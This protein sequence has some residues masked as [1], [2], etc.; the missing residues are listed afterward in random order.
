MITH[1]QTAVSGAD[2]RAQTKTVLLRTRAA[3]AGAPEPI[4]QADDLPA[5]GQAFLDHLVR[6]NLLSPSVAGDF[7]RGHA[8][9]LAAFD[10]AKHT[11]D[12]LVQASL[13][14]RYQ[15]DRILAGNTHGLV[16]GNYRVLAQI[17]AGGM[18]VVFQGEHA[19]MR[20][21]VAIKVLPVDDGCPA[22]MLQR[23]YNEMRVLAQLN[24]P[25]IVTAYDSG[26]IAASAGLPLLL[27]LVMELVD[28]CDLEQYVQRNGRVDIGTA[29]RWICQAGSGLRE[30][31][32]HGLVHRDVKPSN[33]LLAKNGQ[34]K[35]VDFGLVRQFS[36]GLTDPKA[37][38]GTVEYM[39]PEQATDPSSVGTHA[40]IYA[41]GATLFLLLTGQPPYPP[42]ATMRAAVRQLQE[43]QPRRLLQ[44]RP[45][46]PPQLDAALSRLLDRDPMRRPPM[47]HNAMKLLEPFATPG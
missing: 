29:C 17:G 1:Q 4:I 47:V 33:L 45:D 10:D 37:T 12:A 42:T 32:A 39:S 34:I 20:R 11:G 28:G 36:N 7:L 43:G 38:L 9:R 24:H 6:L 27:Y 44:M 23:F 21:K 35:L 22:E 30:A 13:L 31:H 16:L 40:D 2:E 41:L 18:G 14:S 25:N 19:L 26:R 46:A 5:G 8:G 3:A 15:L